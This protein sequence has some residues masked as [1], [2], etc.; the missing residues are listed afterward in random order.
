MTRLTLSFLG[1]LQVL[2]DGEPA[3]GFSTAKVRA[4]LAYLAAEADR[5]HT[6]EALAALLWPDWPD[7]HALNNLRQALANLRA[8]IHDRDPQGTQPFLVISRETI[9]FNGASEHTLDVV[10]FEQELREVGEAPRTNTDEEERIVALVACVQLYRGPFLDGLAIDSAP[11]EEWLTLQRQHWQ[12]EVLAALQQLAEL[13]ERR[14]EYAQA[15]DC[16]RRALVLEPTDER[17]HRQMMRA[18]ALGGERNAALAQ[19]DACARLLDA[20]LGVVPAPE[21]TALYERIR[22]GELV[23]PVHIGPIVGPI[24]ELALP[25]PPRPLFVARE[26]ELAQLEQ[27]LSE[28]L[29]GQ[30]RVGFV[31]GEPGSGKSMLLREFAHR[32][33]AAHPDLIV[34]GGTCNAYAGIGDPYLPFVEILHLLTGH[35]EERVAAGAL[36]REHALRLQAMAPH[37]LQAV[38]QSGAAL[39]DALLPGAVLLEQAQALPD[40]EAWTARVREAL[41]RRVAAP[42]QAFLFDQATRVLQAVAQSHPLVL[43]L[44]DL[45][46]AD[47]ASISLL[48]HLGRRLAGHLLLV[49]GAYRPEEIAAGREGQPHPLQAMLRELQRTWGKMQVDLDSAQGEAFLQALIDSQP[50]QLD[51]G[52]RQALYR[53]TGGHA[54]FTVELLR[55]LQERGDLRHDADGFWVAGPSLDWDALPERVEAVIAERIE[56]LPREQQELLS[57]ASVEGEEFHAEIAARVLKVDGGQALA[58]LSG[59]LSQEHHLVRAH[60]RRQLEKQSFS[61]YRFQHY[62]FQRYLYQRLDPVRRAHLHGEVAAALEALGA[63]PSEGPNALDTLEILSNDFADCYSG[64]DT[65]VSEATMAWHC[66]EACLAERAAHYYY[67]AARRIA[68]LTGAYQEAVAPVRRALDL[69]A[70]LPESPRRTRL[71]YVAYHTLARIL[72]RKGDRPYAEVEQALNN[73]LERAERSGDALLVAEALSWLATGQRLSGDLRRALPL[74]QRAVEL[75]RGGPRAWLSRV[76]GELALVLMYRGDFAASMELLAPLLQVLRG[77]SATEPQDSFRLTYVHFNRLEHVAWALWCQGYP[78][79][80]L[81][82]AKEILALVRREKSRL[83]VGT[84]AMVL[85]GAACFVHQLRRE[86]AG[87]E[88]GLHTLLPEVASVSS[89]PMWGP[90]AT[91]YSGWVHARRGQLPQGIAEL[92]QSVEG[93]SVRT[94]ELPYRKGYLAEA[95][96]AAGQVEEGLAIVEETLAHVERTSERW[97]EAELWRLKGELLAERTYRDGEG[98]KRNHGGHGDFT[99]ATEEKRERQAEECFRRAIEVARGQEARS[100][101]LRATT[102]LARLLR[103]QGRRDEARE[104]LAAVYRW[105]TEGFDTPDLVE[106]KALLDELA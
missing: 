50:N 65:I 90:W 23:A 56:R 52:F 62:L 53:H 105:F 30:G 22:H 55:G 59:P 19:Y 97:S 92:R 75:A 101:E 2:V 58:W 51:E 6:R 78:D 80:A 18:L 64:P 106:A 88:H 69:L 48:F 77:A 7:R 45:Q 86:V 36:R 74:S 40:A 17:W 82:L 96:L 15:Q 93:S 100:W 102:S 46:W 103:D 63:A 33:M 79:Q 73:S 47:A 16:G 44:D 26:Q 60:S 31:V 57:A 29:R 12:R 70:P 14:G 34:A 83:D 39:I 54:L 28:A 71:Q 43:I 81:D 104:M 1:P 72:W 35:V 9:Q 37:T 49:L 32:A 94:A 10:T 76:E 98:E 89:S 24:H 99:E 68:T 66:E 20:E 27:W 8:T 84:E 21:T 87:V 11:F 41:D 67:R 13:H 42:S 3:A 95:L 85:V 91:F 5:P 25:E 4:L 38:L 61:R